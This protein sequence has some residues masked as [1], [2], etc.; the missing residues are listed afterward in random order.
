MKQPHEWTN[1]DGERGAFALAFWT[2][3]DG[4]RLVTGK[5]GEHG[6]KAHVPYTVDSDGK[7]VEA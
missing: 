6:I 7:I 2:K 4:W 3:E 5:V 1:N